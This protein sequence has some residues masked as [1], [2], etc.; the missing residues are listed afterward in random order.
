MPCSV[1]QCGLAIEQREGVAQ[2]E[3]VLLEAGLFAGAALLVTGAGR[4]ALAGAASAMR[5]GGV[6]REQR[7]QQQQEQRCCS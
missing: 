4:D 6:E 5:M 3:Q 7:W 2:I 1:L